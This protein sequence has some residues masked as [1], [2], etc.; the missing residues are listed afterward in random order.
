MTVIEWEIERDTQEDWVLKILKRDEF[1][2]KKA[3]ATVGG[4]IV[5]SMSQSTSKSL[6][7]PFLF[8]N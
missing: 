1:L 4:K 8:K 5:L 2:N 6:S 7:S 3:S